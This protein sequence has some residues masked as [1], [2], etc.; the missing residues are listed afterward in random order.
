MNITSEKSNCVATTLFVTDFF[1]LT[2][3][4]FKILSF[5]LNIV[6]LI[7]TLTIKEFHNIQLTFLYNLNA[8]GMLHCAIG[9]G[10]FFFKTCQ[11]INKTMCYFHSFNELFIATLPGY[12]IS[13]F[14]IHRLACY[15]NIEIKNVFNRCVII[16]S[17]ALIWSLPALFTLIQ[18]FAFE[19]SVN[20]FKTYN[21]CLIDSSKSDYSFYFFAI[22]NTLLPNFVI[23]S[24]CLLIARKV[25][26][27]LKRRKRCR[28]LITERPKLTLL[29]LIYVLMFELSCVSNLVL[30]GQIVNKREI[31]SNELIQ[32]MRILKWLHHFC[33]IFLLFN[34]P[35][36]VEKYKKGTQLDSKK[37]T[38]ITATTL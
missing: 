31:V 36:L 8:I 6:W 9:F 3:S 37:K 24:A 21:V 32:V 29:L 28:N 5:L 25:S 20:Q 14:V 2:I 16:S 35:V 34:H 26:H 19:T 30:F 10:S 33:P 38:L 4:S 12:G 1:N 23:I 22:V 15:T 17:I 18:L 7:V 27:R 13:G 11:T